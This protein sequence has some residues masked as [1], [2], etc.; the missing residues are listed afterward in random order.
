MSN[1]PANIPI[2]LKQRWNDFRTTFLPL[3]VFLFL[4]GMIAFMWTRYVNPAAYLGEVETIR[5][6]LT[7]TLPG[8]LLELKTDRLQPVTNGQC[9]ATISVMEPEI[10]AEELATIAADLHLLKARVDLDKT[11]NVGTWATMRRDLLTE[12]LN[13]G[14]ARVQLEQTENELTRMH[15]LF[16]MK[17][18][19]AGVA[20]TQNGTEPG[21]D[22]AKR[23]RDAAQVEVEQRIK[24]VEQAEADLRHLRCL[25]LRCNFKQILSPCNLSQWPRFGRFDMV[26]RFI[27]NRP[28]E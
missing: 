13:L 5:I 8:T 26:P 3:L 28:R 23:D 10:L 14:I 16:D 27:I 6:N 4:A 12:R 17:L 21:L 1:A 22:M 19:S 7:T 24:S 2:P 15:T 18:I 20:R 25:S 11:R 9:L